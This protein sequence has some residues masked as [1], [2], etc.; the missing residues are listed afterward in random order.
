MALAAISAWSA[1]LRSFIVRLSGLILR[2][3]SNNPGR[4]SL[5]ALL[6]QIEACM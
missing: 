3:Q 4:A 6:Q 5:K 2:K 1:F